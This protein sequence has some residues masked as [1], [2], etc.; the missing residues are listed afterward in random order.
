MS[1][2]R[3]ESD[4][5]G[6]HSTVEAVPLYFWVS[7]PFSTHCQFAF[8]LTSKCCADGQPSHHGPKQ[9]LY[10][11][12]CIWLLL[13]LLQ[14]DDLNIFYIWKACDT[15]LMCCAVCTNM[16]AKPDQT[17]SSAHFSS[18]GWRV[19]DTFI[20]F[21]RVFSPGGRCD[22]PCLPPPPPRTF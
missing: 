5:G 10:L 12:H 9:I 11:R 7:K 22:A 17:P 18:R 1:C 21:L 13:N 3:T 19:S 8:L 15:M 4:W 16:N 6:E 2:V 20:G 14:A